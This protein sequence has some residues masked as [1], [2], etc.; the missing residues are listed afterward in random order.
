MARSAVSFEKQRKSKGS[1]DRC[2]LCGRLLAAGE[3]VYVRTE[4]TNWFRGDDLVQRGVGS[5]C[6]KLERERHGVNSRR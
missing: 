1:G 5:C 6:V 2:S 4:Q 3:N